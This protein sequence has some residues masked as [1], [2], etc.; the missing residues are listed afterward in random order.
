MRLESGRVKISMTDLKALINFYDV[1]PDDKAK[2]LRACEEARR[3]PWWYEYRSLRSADFQAHLRPAAPGTRAERI[4]E[5]RAA[6]PDRRGR[7][8]TCGGQQRVTAKA[9]EY[10]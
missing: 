4:V 2:S 1:N 5:Y 9:S 8:P 10:R 6:I 3:Q 7:A